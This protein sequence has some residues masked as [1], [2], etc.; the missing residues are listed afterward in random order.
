MLSAA[1]T[2]ICSASLSLAMLPAQPA[3][4][5]SAPAFDVQLFESYA[6]AHHRHPIPYLDRQGRLKAF[7]AAWMDHR[8]LCGGAITGVMINL[9]TLSAIQEWQGCSA[10]RRV[11]EK[12]IEFQQ[13][14]WID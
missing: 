9:A 1:K 12:T 6:Q 5:A 2:L 11:G 3:H 7:A 4:T 13:E 10:I 14:V 8:Q